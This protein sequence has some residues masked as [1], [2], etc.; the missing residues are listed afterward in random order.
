MSEANPEQLCVVQP[1]LFNLRLQQQSVVLLGMRGP[2][3]MD[4]ETWVKP[5]LRAYRATVLLA[6]K[7]GKSLSPK[8]H[9]RA[10]FPGDSFMN[11]NVMQNPPVNWESPAPFLFGKSFA[12]DRDWFT[13]VKVFVGNI[14][15]HNSH[16]LTHFTHGCEIIGY[17]HPD[18]FIA[19][20]FLYLYYKVVEA[21]HF[22]PETEEQMDERLKDWDREFWS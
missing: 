7:Y 13:V 9:D 21:L 16:F 6:A 4:K 22:N 1:W 11:Y 5:V 10:A 3:G 18:K 2:D 15:P 20:H 12:I 19:E 8:P 14:D 17:K